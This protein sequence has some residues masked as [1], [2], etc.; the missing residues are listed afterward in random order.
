MDTKIYHITHY[1][2]LKSILQSGELSCCANIQTNQVSY[3]NIAHNNIQDRRARF[4]VPIQPGGVVHDYVPF[5]F[6]TRSPMLYAIHQGAVNG[7]NGGQKDVIYLVSSAERIEQAGY[8]YVFT[9]GHAI[10][11][12]SNYYS[13]LSDLDKIDW[14]IMRSRYWNDN[15]E[16]NDRKR[17]RQ[18]E[19]LVYDKLKFHDVEK[20][21]TYD[22][23]MQ[24]SV[25]DNLRKVGHHIPVEV[26]KE[27]YY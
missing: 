12:F 1:N 3:T 14:N 13:N 7:Y 18:A 8:G 26:N 25:N 24:N 11:G 15:A 6:A 2:N 21:V 27:W 19:F 5:Y 9:D 4:V 10:M 16:D 23:Q 17:R 22:T 20:I